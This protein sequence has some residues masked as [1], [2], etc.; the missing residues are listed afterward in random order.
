M[1]VVLE[2]LVSHAPD[3]TSSREETRH[4]KSKIKSLE[5]ELYFYKKT[6]RDFR[7]QLKKINS[8][9]KPGSYTQHHLDRTKRRAK[10]NGPPPKIAQEQTST[11]V[12]S[13]NTKQE[14]S[15][16]PSFVRDSLEVK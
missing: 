2:K 13:A 5:K 10:G 6:S 11:I 15:L 3:D 12:A 8:Q 16:P 14:V 1:Q 4:L 9:K 7:H